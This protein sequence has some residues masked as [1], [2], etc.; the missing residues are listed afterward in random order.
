MAQETIT[1]AS[2]QMV[3]ANGQNKDGEPVFQKKTYS[4]LSTSAVGDDILSVASSISSLQE[5]ELT[6]VN[7]VLVKRIEA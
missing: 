4:N 2:L 6:E 3:Y 1:S 7:T 5:K